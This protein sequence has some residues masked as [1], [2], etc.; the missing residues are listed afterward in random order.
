[1]A[2]EK[3]TLFSSGLLSHE[4]WWDIY[5]SLSFVSHHISVSLIYCDTNGDGRGLDGMR[6]IGVE[7]LDH[8]LRR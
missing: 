2:F 6:Q 1:M 5:I 7:G 4:H 3:A 8:I